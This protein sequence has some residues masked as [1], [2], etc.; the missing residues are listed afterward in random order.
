MGEGFFRRGDQCVL[1]EVWDGKVWTAKPVTV[2]C[3][4]HDLI[5]LYIAPGTPWKKPLKLDGSELKMPTGDWLLSDAEWEDERNLQL[6]VPGEAHSVLACWKGDPCAFACWYINLEEPLSRTTRGFACMDQVLDIVVSPDCATWHWK[7]EEAFEEAQTLGVIT[8]EAA[9]AILAEGERAIDRMR[10]R[11]PPFD[12]DWE[13]WRPD[14]AW[15][16]PRFR[17]EWG[18]V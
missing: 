13:C 16:V 12:R 2:V 1:Q 3:D 9:K 8:P 7:D 10:R 4:T 5:A 11:E 15:R 6:T 18:S 17:P 14:P